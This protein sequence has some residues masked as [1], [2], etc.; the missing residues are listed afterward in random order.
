MKLN[1]SLHRRT[2]GRRP[3]PQE[4]GVALITVLAI[5]LLMTVLI[6]SFFTM[7]SN[8]RAAVDSQAAQ[9]SIAQLLDQPPFEHHENVT[10]WRFGEAAEEPDEADAEALREWLE[11]FFKLSEMW[12][13]VEAVALFFERAPQ[14]QQF[15]GWMIVAGAATFP[16]N[17]LALYPPLLRRLKNALIRVQPQLP[18][19]LNSTPGRFHQTCQQPQ[20]GRLACT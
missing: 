4:K 15:L 5:V 8:W 18:A 9:Q 17:S 1:P 16:L 2:D 10:R 20:D 19:H 7:S 12:K 3:A 6:T 11:R 14:A 13:S